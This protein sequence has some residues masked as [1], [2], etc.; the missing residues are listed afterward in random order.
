MEAMKSFLAWMW[1]LHLLLALWLATG[2]FA[3]AVVLAQV[4]RTTDAAERAFGFRLAW[5]LMTVFI[6]PGVLV[7]GALGFYLVS[8]FQYGFGKGW[9]QVSVGLYVLLLASIFLVQVP[10]FRKALHAGHAGENAELERLARSPLPV[11]L[12][13]VNAL[14]I[15]VMIILMAMKP[16]P[17]G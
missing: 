6:V 1:V 12:N 7:A 5:R 16:T 17:G 3:S 14:I 2:V 11:M 9:V 4:K 8:G 15:L 13:H 10:H